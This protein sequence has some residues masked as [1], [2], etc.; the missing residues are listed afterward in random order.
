LGKV[1]GGPRNYE[2]DTVTAR[3]NR[4]AIRLHLLRYARRGVGTRGREVTHLGKAG[5]KVPEGRKK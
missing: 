3:G 4:N 5:T 2:G 1:L